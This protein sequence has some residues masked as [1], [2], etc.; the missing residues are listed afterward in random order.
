[1]GTTTSITWQTGLS[2]HLYFWHLGTLTLRAE[3]QSAW[4]SKITNDGLTWSG[5]GCF[6]YSCTNMAT[7]GIKGL[8]IISTV[9]MTAKK[10][11]RRKCLQSSAMVIADLSY[12]FKLRCKHL[13][14]S[15]PRSVEVYD[16][17]LSAG[18]HVTAEL[19]R[20]QANDTTRQQIKQPRT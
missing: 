10:W 11:D 7:V 1:M 15:T 17:W 12:L 9:D 8:I 5:T 6:N 3:R 20:S 19:R 18:Q 14:V 4:M 2:R 13:T 16:P